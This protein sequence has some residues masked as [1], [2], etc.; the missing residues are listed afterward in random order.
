MKK[1]I[2]IILIIVLAILILFSL[3]FIIGGSEDDWICT[4]GKWVKHG[5][6]SAPQPT[7]LCGDEKLIGGDKDEHGCLG[8]AG[9]QWCPSQEKCLRMWEEYCEEYKEQYRGEIKTD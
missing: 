5:Q 6:P 2:I 3:R 9:Y 8:S 7:E 4:D 1:I